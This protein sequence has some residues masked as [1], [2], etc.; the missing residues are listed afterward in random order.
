MNQLG[1]AIKF[2]S[3][4]KLWL[5]L[6]VC[7]LTA[8]SVSRKHDTLFIDKESYCNPPVASTGVRY[9]ISANTDSVLAANL[10]LS[11]R[12]SVQ[13]ILLIHA[14]GLLDEVK[15]VALIKNDSLN[16]STHLQLMQRISSR[17]LLVSSEIN[18][19]A[20]E[21]D[22]EGER[23]DQIAK[24]VD[25]L[26]AKHNT[27]FTVA[28][29]VVGAL[30]GVAGAFISQPGW[31]KGVAI[32]AGAA[33][34]GLGLATLNPKGK[35]VELLHQRNLLRNVWLQQNNSEFSPFLWFML[36]EKRISNTAAGSLLSNLRHRWVRYQFDGDSSA[37][38]KSVNFTGG[39]IYNA[40][41]LHNR[42]EMINQ[43]QAEIRS[44]EQ[45]VNLFLR[46]L[47]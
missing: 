37:A 1:A 4:S 28:S 26:N 9:A 32:G 20:A 7:C 31:N 42:A 8:C 11:S 10:A 5:L 25:D 47:D 6:Y 18:A 35:K 12:F 30:S 15:Q 46:E 29:I 2:V 45:Q 13:S 39:G 40:A 23:L 44:I 33:G 38:S 19:I 24:Y 22:C 36:S 17:V 3:A 43:L 34:I 41:E 14:L 16:S 21:L 27:R